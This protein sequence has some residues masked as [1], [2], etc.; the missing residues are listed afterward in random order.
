MILDTAFVVDVMKNDSDAVERYELL[1]RERVQQK[2]SSMTLFELY[3][4]I[5]RSMSARGER[6]QVLDVLDTKQIVP[7]DAPVMR[8]AGRLHGRLGNDG[9]AIGESDCI[10]AATA[11]V[12]DEPVL[13]RNV[14]HF[15]RV[16]AVEV[17]TY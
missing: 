3:H 14:D 9:I 10:I 15:D 1:E 11:T 16:D 8:K 13:T 5:E 6:K 7:A 12:H 4:G 2:L 17:R